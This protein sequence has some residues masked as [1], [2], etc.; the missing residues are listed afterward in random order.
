L[1]A[2]ALVCANSL[3][4]IPARAAGQA[5]YN[6][7]FL[8]EISTWDEPLGH[9]WVQFGDGHDRVFGF[10]PV[11]DTKK[12][13]LRLAGEVSDDSYRGA[14]VS[15]RFWVSDAA[16]ARGLA[17]VARYRSSND[18]FPITN[19]KSMV[20]DIARALGLKTPLTFMKSPAEYLSSLV[21][22][23]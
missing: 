22:A 15:Y 10:Y 13:A 23:N 8:A 18:V 9:I 6:V 1:L 5:Q 11:G 20:A 19:C 16:F 17:V 3:P 14:D 21:E 12:A 7:T 4:P 2:L